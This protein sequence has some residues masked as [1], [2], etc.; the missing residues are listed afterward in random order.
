M[1]M[2]KFSKQQGFTM[3]ELMVV[4]VILGILA[5]MVVPNVMGNKE[6]AMKQKAVSDITALETALKMYKLH[7]NFYPST[8]QGLE[9]L[10]TQTDIEPLPRTFPEEGYLPR[11]P[12][13]P[14]NNEYLL[15]NPGEHGSMDIFSAGPDGEAGSEDDIGNWNLTDFQ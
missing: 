4:I 2:K 8:D 13:D 3:L 9:A 14:W 5:S 10:V 7:N 1:K 11:L 15:L 6:I 12:K